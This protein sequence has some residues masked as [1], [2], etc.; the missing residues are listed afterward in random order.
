MRR[1]RGGHRDPTARAVTAA[2]FH[3]ELQSR[4]DATIT[5]RYLELLRLELGLADGVPATQ[6]EASRALGVSRETVLELQPGVD[7]AIAAVGPDFAELRDWIDGDVPTVSAALRARLN[8]TSG[9]A[10][11]TLVW[12]SRHGWRDPSLWL[13]GMRGPCLECSCPVAPTG[14]GPTR[15]YCSNACRQAAYRARRRG[16]TAACPPGD[17]SS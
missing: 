15:V 12:C 4:L 7:W 5:R 14:M 10:E 8:Q 16:E 2:A 6:E 1:R 9:Q 17:E 13:H 3:E 11:G